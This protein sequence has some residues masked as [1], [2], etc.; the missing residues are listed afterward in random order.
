ME[1]SA[2]VFEF[3]DLIAQEAHLPNSDVLRKNTFAEF[4]KGNNKKNIWL[5]GCNAVGKKLIELCEGEL[6]IVGILD[7]SVAM[8]NRELCGV[9]VFDPNNIV[10]TLIEDRDVIIITLR[11]NADIVY[12]QIVNMGFL[13][14]F[15]LGVLIAGIEP[16]RSFLAELQGDLAQPL[17]S[18]IILMESMNDFDGNVGA[19][20]EYMKK[21]GTDYRFV[22]ICKSEDSSH[23][24]FDGNDI[25]LIPTKSVDDLK[26]Y[27]ILRA[28]AKWEIW[29]C[30]AIRKVRKDQVNV[31]LQHYGMGY[32]QVAHLYNSPDYVGYVLT[33]NEFVCELEKKSI[34]YAD[35]L[36]FI[37][38]ELPR[39]D[40]L[41]YEWDEISKITDK[42]FDKI[43]MWAPTL[44]ESK[45]YNRVDSDI[46]YPFGISLIYDKA[47]MEL[48]NEKLAELDILLLIKIHP[49]QKINFEELEYT[50]I[51]YL[52]GDSIKKIHAYKLLSQMDALIT[53]YS[54][55]VFDYMLLDRP[56]A[57]VLE[58][59]DHY[60]IEYLMDNPDE[61]MPGGKIY[62]IDD[63]LKFLTNVSEGIDTYGDQR[64]KICG[65]CNYPFD[66]KG[67][68][69]LLE[70]LGL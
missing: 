9:K 52:D 17:K 60:K 16:Y 34:T 42:S 32:K 50:N 38:G 20:Y 21:T 28:T 5:F 47:D 3:W 27:M 10:P 48:L 62:R 23:E 44:R 11:L 30:D 31:F 39:N 29:E 63:L 18:D 4:V 13:N 26:K 19:L 56:C 67:S 37:F 8:W 12:R 64:R 24:Y 35:N 58:D 14:I 57:W 69:R 65:R 7:N 25:K 46:L 68:E 40:V 22:W 33:T 54:S 70:V 51:I 15:S 41:K 36:K 2:D 61:Y 45:F 1:N 55:I 66:G 53:D 43:V 6:N 59:R 49:R